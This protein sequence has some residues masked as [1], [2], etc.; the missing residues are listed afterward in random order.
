METEVFVPGTRAIG[1]KRKWAKGAVG[2]P[3]PESERNAVFVKK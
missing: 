1:F 3:E 2:W